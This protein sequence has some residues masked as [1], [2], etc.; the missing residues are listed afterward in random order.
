M[1]STGPINTKQHFR[2]INRIWEKA[3]STMFSVTSSINPTFL[4]FLSFFLSLTHSL[5]F[6]FLHFVVEEKCELTISARQMKKIYLGKRRSQRLGFIL[7]KPVSN[8]SEH[9]SNRQR[10]ARKLKRNQKHTKI[11]FKLH[12]ICL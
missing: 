1:L 8:Y 11:I 4:N 5:F 6:L 10:C 12:I 9:P 2:K 7:L 3:E